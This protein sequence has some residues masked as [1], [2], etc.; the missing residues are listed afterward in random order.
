MKTW[1]KDGVDTAG[2]YSKNILWNKPTVQAS[3]ADLN[4]KYKNITFKYI[5]K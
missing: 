2:L 5:S 4:N 1:G 3:V